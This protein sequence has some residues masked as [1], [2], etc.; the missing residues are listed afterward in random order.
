M[1]GGQIMASHQHSFHRSARRGHAHNVSYRSH[2]HGEAAR[3][4]IVARLIAAS[5]ALAD[6][7]DAAALLLDGAL[8]QMLALFPA[9]ANANRPEGLDALDAQAPEIAC[10]ACRLRLALQSHNPAARLAHCWALLDLLTQST[11]TQ[12][13]Q[14]AH[15]AQASAHRDVSSQ[16]CR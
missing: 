8:S 9:A 15:L 6:D 16:P 10:I 2:A 5:H 13:T 1:E 11:T 14:R 4:R 12:S 7:P 3:A